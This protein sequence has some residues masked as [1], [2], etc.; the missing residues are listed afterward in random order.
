VIKTMWVVVLAVILA[1]G[2]AACGGGGK[3]GSDDS[4]TMSNAE[5]NTSGTDNGEDAKT[6]GETPT[7]DANSLENGAEAPGED[8]R[9]YRT[10]NDPDAVY[11]LDN[12]TMKGSYLK[13]DFSDLTADQLNRVLHRL[14][15]EVCTC[16]C[17]NDPIDQC[18]VNDPACGTAVTLATQI[19]REE[20]M[21]S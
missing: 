16:G 11:T 12:I 18:L 3:A 5:P 1:L 7:E 20:K 2:A 6:L 9:S 13:L 15:T 19:I 21:K 14:R 10:Q 8:A 4:A 17:P